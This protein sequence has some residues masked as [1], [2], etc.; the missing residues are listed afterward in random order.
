MRA[1]TDTTGEEK[2]KTALRPPSLLLETMQTTRQATK[3][4]TKHAA[5][6]AAQKAATKATAE[7][8]EAVKALRRGRKL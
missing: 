8:K 1:T 7:A 6:E 2:L 3:K 4:A 5:T